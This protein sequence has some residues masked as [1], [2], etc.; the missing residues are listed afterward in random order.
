M[1]KRPCGVSLT[2][3][4]TAF[5]FRSQAAPAAWA[6]GSCDSVAPEAPSALAF[7]V[8]RRG[9]LIA[10]TR[11]HRDALASFGAPPRQ[12]GLAALGLH[13]LAK[14]V[15]LGTPAAVRL[16]CPLRHLTP[17]LLSSQQTTSACRRL[18]TPRNLDKQIKSINERCRIGQTPGSPA[19]PRLACWGGNTAVSGK[20]SVRFAG[21]KLLNSQFKNLLTRIAIAR[22]RKKFFHSAPRLLQ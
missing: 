18:H 2:R 11:A 12:H 17:I 20:R 8:L 22:S 4:S 1:G 14:A 7:G 9:T 19:R 10:I 5:A 15:H 3:E 16:E 13:P 21:W 6:V